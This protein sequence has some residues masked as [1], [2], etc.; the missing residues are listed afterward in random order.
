MKTW[1]KFFVSEWKIYRDFLKR[2]NDRPGIAVSVTPEMGGRSF[3]RPLRPRT[4]TE[5]ER[6]RNVI[7]DGPGWEVKSET[8]VR[9]TDFKAIY[10][11]HRVE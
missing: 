11:S 6:S 10:S 2:G 9:S 5:I 3:V 1:R 8:R 4:L 7:E